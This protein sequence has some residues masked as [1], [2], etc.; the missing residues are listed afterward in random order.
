MIDTLPLKK[1]GRPLLLGNEL[2]DQ[3]KSYIKDARAAGTPIDTTVVMASGEAIVRKTD[4]NL[5][6]ENGGPIDIT[7]S[8]A[9][10]LSFT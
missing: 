9:K 2:D 8:W 3:V 6:K 1:R 10:L 5:L 4:K 7:K